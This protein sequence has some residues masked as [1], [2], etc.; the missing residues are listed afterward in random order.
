MA[1]PRAIPLKE[2]VMGISKVDNSGRDRH[3]KKIEFECSQMARKF[4]LAG[5]SLFVKLEP[6]K[7]RLRICCKYAGGFSSTIADGRPDLQSSS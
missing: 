1:K 5:K 7:N 3:E 4:L 6:P 2:V